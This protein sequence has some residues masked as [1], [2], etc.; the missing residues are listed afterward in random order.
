MMT[1]MFLI[2]KSKLF[3]CCVNYSCFYY[4]T[5]YSCMKVYCCHRISPIFFQSFFSQ[6]SHFHCFIR[7]GEDPC[8]HIGDLC[9]CCCCFFYLCVKSMKDG[10]FEMHE[11]QNVMSQSAQ[12]KSNN[13]CCAKEFFFISLFVEYLLSLLFLSLA[14]H[15]IRFVMVSDHKF[16]LRKITM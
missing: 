14:T 4:F 15:T 10:H 9:V 12:N 2:G 6:L 13:N 16:I 11:E 3:F 5:I 8:T 1:V 7:S